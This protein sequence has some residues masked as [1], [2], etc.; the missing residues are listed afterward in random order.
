MLMK[1][2]RAFQLAKKQQKNN[3]IA[4]VEKCYSF[5]KT[6]V[7]DQGCGVARSRRFLDGV[8][9]LRTLEVGVGFFYPTPTDQS[10]YFYI[11]LLT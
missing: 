4:F 3:A 2:E 11:T 1:Y 10:N 9:F 5:L 8:G 6:G 7:S